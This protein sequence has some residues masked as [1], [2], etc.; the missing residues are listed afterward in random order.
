GGVVGAAWG[1]SGR[2][3]RRVARR[4][5]RHHVAARYAAPRP[6]ARIAQREGSRPRA[7]VDPR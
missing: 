6:V 7:W 3:P 5:R 2:R 1:E 4:A